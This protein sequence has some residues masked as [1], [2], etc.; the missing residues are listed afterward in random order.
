V[1]VVTRKEYELIGKGT[2]IDWPALDEELSVTGFI[3]DTIK[4]EVMGDSR[5]I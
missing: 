4:A 1:P 3:R 5:I 2:G